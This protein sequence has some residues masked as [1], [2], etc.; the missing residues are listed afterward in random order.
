MIGMTGP[1]PPP[2]SLACFNSLAA[3]Y[4]ADLRDLAAAVLW[5]GCAQKLGSPVP[6]LS[7]LELQKLLSGTIPELAPTY[8]GKGSPRASPRNTCCT[9]ESRSSSSTAWSSG[10]SAGR[11]TC[12]RRS[13]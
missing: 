9:R 1:P 7:M 13:R 8:W 4:Q 11:A 5:M 6:K 2:P 10:D 12:R 3:L